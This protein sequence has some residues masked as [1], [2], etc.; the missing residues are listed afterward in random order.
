MNTRVTL[1]I[2]GLLLALAVGGSGWLFWVQNA[3]R[4][5]MLSL[6]LG[7]TQLQLIEP[8]PVPALMAICFGIGIVVG[9]G[10]LVPLLAR[11]NARARVATRQA[12]L[13]IDADRGY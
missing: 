3:S 9:G 10:I 11:A 2:I 5:V 7:F 8:L 13:G 1:L 6:N 12:A 4:T